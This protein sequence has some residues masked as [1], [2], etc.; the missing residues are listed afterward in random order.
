ML[1]RGHREHDARLQELIS[2]PT[3][4]KG[5]LWP[6]PDA[7]TPQQLQ[8]LAAEQTEGRLAV[9]ALDATWDNANRMKSKFPADVPQLQIPLD[10]A[11]SHGS[12]GS[13][14]APLR[15][16]SK[17]AQGRVCT[18]EAVA[19]ALLALEPEGVGEEMYEGLLNNLKMKVDAMRRQKNMATVYDTV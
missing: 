12:Q 9:I 5:I 16:Y 8:Q 19:A 1:M 14:F 15:K 7:L 2:D 6:G 10:L 3:I 18:L 13:L 11:L 4:T 17:A